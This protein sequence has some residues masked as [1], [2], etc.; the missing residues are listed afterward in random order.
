MRSARSSTTSRN[1][2]IVAAAIAIVAT[3]FFFALGWYV[4]RFGEPVALVAFEHATVNHGAAVAWW[5][6]HTCYLYVLAP[7]GL[8]LLVA[9]WRLPAWR[10]R[11][12][13]SLVML[14]LAWRGAAFFQHLYARPRRLDWV[15][16]HE[17][18]FSFP[19]SHASISL[20]FYGLWALFIWQRGVRARRWIT[21]LLAALVVGIYWSRLALGAHYVTDLLGGA[22]L[23]IA[24]VSAGSAL[25]PRKVLG[26]TRPEP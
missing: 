9:A 14:L 20:G 10:V 15:L 24:L 16:I 7:I 22:L 3:L 13:F 8:I 19:S 11:I 5:F 18:S 6:T 17:R 23:A 26:V 25:L 2:R 1:A 21:P 12:L 4:M